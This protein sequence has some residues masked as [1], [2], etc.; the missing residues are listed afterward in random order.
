MHDEQVQR[1]DSEIASLADQLGRS[2]QLLVREET[3][4]LRPLVR[5][6][7]RTGRAVGR[8]LPPEWQDTAC[9]Y[10]APAARRLAPDSAATMVYQIARQRRSGPPG[11]VSSTISPS[12]TELTPGTQMRSGARRQMWKAS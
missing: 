5:R 7:L 3:R 8:R 2:T 10:L 6:A 9:A 12:H 4:V 1:L 11:P